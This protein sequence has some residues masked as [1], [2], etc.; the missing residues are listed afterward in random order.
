[1]MWWPSHLARPSAQEVS[2]HDAVTAAR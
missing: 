1:V 2:L